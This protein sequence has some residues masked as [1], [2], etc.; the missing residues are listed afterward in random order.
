MLIPLGNLR[1]G[2]NRWM[3]SLMFAL[4]LSSLCVHAILLYISST[5]MPSLFAFTVIMLCMIS[6]AAVAWLGC[7]PNKL[8]SSSRICFL[9]CATNTPSSSFIPF[10]FPFFL[11]TPVCVTTLAFC[12]TS[13]FC[14]TDGST[15]PLTTVFPTGILFEGSSVTSAAISDVYSVPIEMPSLYAYPC[16]SNCLLTSL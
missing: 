13:P 15:I 10:F 2:W 1:S 6:A 8:I 7:R 16:P 14:V 5:E 9:F 3:L 4:S 11:P 12:T